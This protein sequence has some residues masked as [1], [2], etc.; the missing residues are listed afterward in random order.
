MKFYELSTQFNNAIDELLYSDDLDDATIFD[1]LEGIEGQLIDKGRNVCAYILNQESENDALDSHIKA[2]QKKLKTRKAQS[3]SL[4]DYLKINMLKAGITEIKA[5]DG[6]FTAK[7]GKG[8]ESVVIDDES[9][10][11]EDC[12]VIKKEVSK[13]AVKAYIDDHGGCLGAHIER[14]ESLTIK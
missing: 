6:T 1:T 12:I 7:I 9:L 5:N 11:P 10:I 13:T 14:K 2:M 8:R 4:R 3:A